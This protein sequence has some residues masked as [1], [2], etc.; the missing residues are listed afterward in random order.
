MSCDT[1]DKFGKEVVIVGVKI[2]LL[3]CSG[4]DTGSDGKVLVKC[5]GVSRGC[6]GGV[7]GHGRSV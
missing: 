5:G 2:F 7:R 3:L 6:K 4:R 1:C